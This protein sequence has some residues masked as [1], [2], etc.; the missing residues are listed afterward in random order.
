VSNDQAT[1]WALVYATLNPKDSDHSPNSCLNRL[2]NER[3]SGQA[4]IQ[5]NDRTA[6]VRK[7]LW[8]TVQLSILDKKH[9]RAHDFDDD[10]PI[11]VVE[12]CNKKILV[13]GNHQVARWLSSAHQ[14]QHQVL[15]LSLRNEQQ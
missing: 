10:R 14:S 13:D 15:L 8:P 9:N 12:Y 1:L 7:E 3:L 2:T 11:V 6:V 4:Y 5:L